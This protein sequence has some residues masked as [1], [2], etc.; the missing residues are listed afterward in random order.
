MTAE[1]FLD[2]GINIRVDVLLVGAAGS[3]R[4]CS[5]KKNPKNLKYKKLFSFF[6]KKNCS[7]FS[8]F[9][10]Y[11]LKLYHLGLLC[12]PIKFTILSL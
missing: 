5:G 3:S 6:L 1:V 10:E 11:N 4:C 12:L 9:L 7:F 8:F 2:L